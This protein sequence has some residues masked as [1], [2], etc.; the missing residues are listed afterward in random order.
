M[1]KKVTKTEAPKLSQTEALSTMVVLMQKKAKHE[2]VW[3]WIVGVLLFL[4]VVFFY[5]GNVI[6]YYLNAW[7]YQFI[8][9]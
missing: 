3:R 1:K 2:C 8:N 9:K 6:T 7:L 4:L 5:F